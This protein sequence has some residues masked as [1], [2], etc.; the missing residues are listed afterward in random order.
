MLS[1]CR[2][3]RSRYQQYLDDAKK[4]EALEKE[5]ERKTEIEKELSNLRK[6]KRKLESSI[7]TMQKDAD[8]IALEAE[9][10]RKIELLSKSN[11]FRA[12]ATDMKKDL[13]VLDAKISSLQEKLNTS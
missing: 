10:K 6:N 7:V 8:D 3:A 2:A 13:T 1:D 12:K 5:N 9:K 4:L 11:A